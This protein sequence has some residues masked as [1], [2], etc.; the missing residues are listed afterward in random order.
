MVKYILKRVFYMFLVLFIVTTITFF[1][2]HM[3]PGD[4]LTALVQKLPEQ[5]KINY[6]AKYGLDKPVY[7]QYF[8]FLKGIFTEGT[9]GE[10]I[11]F[12]GRQVLDTI[13]KYA[14][15]SSE[16]GLVAVLIGFIIGIVLGTVSAIKQNK[17]PDKLISIIAILGI[18]LPVFLLASLFQYLFTVKWPLFPTLGWGTPAHKILP[19]LC[20]SFSPLAT[21]TRYMRSSV[22]DVINQDYITMAE[23]KGMSFAQVVRRHVLRN[24]ILPSLTILGPNIADVFTGSFVI[25]SIFA[26][27]GLGSYYITAVNDRDFP[28]IIGCAM[29]YTGIY[30]LSLLVVDILYVIID[31]RI[32]LTGSNSK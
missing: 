11:R 18:S 3:I 28:M 22:L 7:E 6:Y 27:P 14:G 13:Q 12:P 31:P 21:Y 16:I 30:I 29:F 20:M 10:S 25:E 2:M 4:P 17:L 19:I 1:L 15:Y 24:S 8:V 32:R 26:I 9:L 23:A 5:T